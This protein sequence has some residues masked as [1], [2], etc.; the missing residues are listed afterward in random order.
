MAQLKDTI[1]T[2]DLSVTGTIHGNIPLDN[3]TDAD[4]LKA[5]EALTGTSGILTKTAENTWNLSNGVAPASHVHGNITNAGAIGTAANKGVYTGTDGVLTAGTIP[6]AAGGT[7]AASFTANSVV[8]SGSSTTAALTTRAITNITAKGN[9]GWTSTLGSNIPTLNTLAYWNG[10]YNSSSSNLQYCNKGEFGNAVTYGVDDATANGALGTGTGLTTERSV[11][12]GLVTVNNASQTR[13][14]GIYAPTSAGTAGYILKSS[15]GTAAPVWLQTLPIAN[16]GTGNTTGTAALVTTAA[17]TTNELITLGVTSDATTTLKRDTNLLIKSNTIYPP[18]I[19]ESS[20]GTSAKPFFKGFFDTAIAIRNNSDSG[21]RGVYVENTNGSISVKA[22]NARG[23]FD[24]TDSEWMVYKA[25]GSGNL[26]RTT[27]PA[28]VGFGLRNV[29]YG[30]DIA[31]GGNDGD[32]YVQYDSN[33]T[34]GTIA[35]LLGEAGKVYFNYWDYSA[36]NISTTSSYILYTSTIPLLPKGTY[37]LMGGG[38]LY[39]SG[40]TARLCLYI[41]SLQYSICMTNSTSSDRSGFGVRP[42]IIDSDLT[43]PTLTLR[44]VSQSTSVIAY[45][46]AYEETSCVLI[47]LSDGIYNT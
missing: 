43:N 41:N 46:G 39:C 31:S 17:D 12:Y 19:G 44:L 30:T 16:G 25:S 34:S 13:A 38:G 24:G 37:L 42:I 11:Y 35:S 15:G 7:G 10:R 23:L 28:S 29:S 18:A 8:I 4:N 6:V 20:V 47:R 14:T 40:Q 27:S 9:L 3:L 32:I 5:I 45:L 1:V 2:G 26:T 21:E 22:A 36:G 33:A